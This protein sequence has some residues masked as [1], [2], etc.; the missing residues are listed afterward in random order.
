[1]RLS[2]SLTWKGLLVAV[3]GAMLMRSDLQGVSPLDPLAVGG[4][5][6]VLLLSA[7]LA[8]LI[9]AIRAARSDPVETLRESL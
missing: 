2:F 9:P 8:S 4:G 7:L 3:P 6:L 5:C 1:M